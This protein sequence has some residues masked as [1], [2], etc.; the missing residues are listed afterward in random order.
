MVQGFITSD[1][2]LSRGGRESAQSAV[3]IITDGKYSLTYQKAKTTRE[4]KGK[5]VRILSCPRAKNFK[6]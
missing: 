2:M 1:G 5:E 3:P 6:C 4:L